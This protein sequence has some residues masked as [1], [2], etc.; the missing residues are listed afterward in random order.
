MKLF[1][2]RHT[3]VNV[4][5]GFCYGQSEVALADT[6]QEEIETV[7]SQLQSIS[8]DRIYS[9]PLSRCAIL[10][11]AI[12]SNVDDIHYDHRLMELDFGLWE[13]QY[14]IDI[15][16]TPEAKVWFEDYINN[17]C[18]NGESH[19]DFKCR[20]SEFIVELKKETTLKNVAII[21]H[22]GTIRIFHSI[23]QNISSIQS[24]QLKVDFGQILEMELNTYL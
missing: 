18:P 17:N 23:I 12:A 11:Q 21:C 13:G 9:S 5:T 2:I 16:K 20:V 8:F 22:A 3:R 14:W 7:L 15:E 19:I 6:Y 24:F 1:L 10:A 4:P